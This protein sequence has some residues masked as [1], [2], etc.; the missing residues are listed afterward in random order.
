MS[1]IIFDI[2][3]NCEFVYMSFRVPYQEVTTYTYG[4]VGACLFIGRIALDTVFSVRHSAQIIYLLQGLHL[5]VLV[6]VRWYYRTSFV[7]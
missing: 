5:V 7:Q 6:V 2:S 3:Q 1:F 4:S